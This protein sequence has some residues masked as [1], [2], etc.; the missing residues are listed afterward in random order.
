MQALRFKMIDYKMIKYKVDCCDF[1]MVKEVISI[2]FRK[3]ILNGD[4]SL[5]HISNMEDD[6]YVLS[7][8]LLTDVSFEKTIDWFV[9]GIDWGHYGVKKPCKLKFIP[10]EDR[11]VEG[12]GPWFISTNGEKASE[13]NFDESKAI[14]VEISFF[15]RGE[16]K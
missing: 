16:V 8:E 7:I 15:N 10:P 11:V 12:D 4:I 5:G 3:E 13:H 14:D 1:D 6:S 2:N 9:D